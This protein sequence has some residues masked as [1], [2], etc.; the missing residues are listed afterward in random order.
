MTQAI[1]KKLNAA[2][3]SPCQQHGSEDRSDSR[4]GTRYC[5]RLAFARWWKSLLLLFVSL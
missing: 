5:F 3:D 1:Q 4:H 2:C